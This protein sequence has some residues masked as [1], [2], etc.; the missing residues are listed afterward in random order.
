MLLR[1]VVPRSMWSVSFHG[2]HKCLHGPCYSYSSGVIPKG[3]CG[4]PFLE[5]C[6]CKKSK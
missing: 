5:V 4:I 1:Y 6:N 2:I 3:T